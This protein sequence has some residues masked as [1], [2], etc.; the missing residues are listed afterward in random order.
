MP[1]GIFLDIRMP[2]MDG[3]RALEAIRRE[4]PHLTIIMISASPYR[5]HRRE[6]RVFGANGWP[7]ETIDPQ[8]LK[9]VLRDWFGW[10]P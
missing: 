3:F 8:P 1:D 2:V 9:T 5:R 10:I 6:A 4:H 7:S